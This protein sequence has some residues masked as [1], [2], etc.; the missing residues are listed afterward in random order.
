MFHLRFILNLFILSFLIMGS[1]GIFSQE[2]D[3]NKTDLK[4]KLESI[5]P[6]TVNI[7]SIEETNIE[8]Y[9]EISFE[10]IEP[11]YVSMDG[12][13]LIS[14]D[15]YQITKEGLVNES[16]SRRSFQRKIALSKQKA[17]EFI[18]FEPKFV[19][20]QIFVFTDVDCGYCRQFH[21]E[22]DDFLSLGIQVNYLAFPRT[23]MDSLSFNKI[24]SA[25][26]S[27]DPN[28]SLTLLKQGGQIR[29]NICPENP[30]E[31]HFNLGG[32]FGVS[33]TPSIVTSE[34]KL[35]PGYLP[36]DELIRLLGS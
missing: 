5:L 35:I 22:I 4:N 20:H 34:G 26:C 19:E 24:A 30:V 12:K 28:S 1:S 25:W 27:D 16:E 32:S 3:I 6:D 33:G 11:L 8:G 29:E 10:G 21:R 15:I 14:G 9:F 13:Y 17:S 23:G 2:L 18:T 7:V 31:R 36:A